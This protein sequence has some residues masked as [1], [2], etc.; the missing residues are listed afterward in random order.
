MSDTISMTKQPVL[1]LEDSFLDIL[2]KAQR[3][4]NLNDQ[5]LASRAGVSAA[6]LGRINAGEVDA[7]VLSKLA[8]AL[9]LGPKALIDAADKAWQPQPVTVPGLEVFTTNFEDMTV[10]SY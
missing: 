10:N 8:V 3:G 6:D 7:D 5:E 9:N 4:L 2:G 1:P